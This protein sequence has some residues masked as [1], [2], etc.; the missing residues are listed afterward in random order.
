MR[1]KPK[2]FHEPIKNFH[3]ME[4]PIDSV[5]IEI[6][7]YRQKNLTTLYYRIRMIQISNAIQYWISYPAFESKYNLVY[8]TLLFHYY[9]MKNTVTH[10]VYYLTL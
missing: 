10:Y 3:T 9:Y 1:K 4:S 7:S 5:V 2:T 8:F 6:L